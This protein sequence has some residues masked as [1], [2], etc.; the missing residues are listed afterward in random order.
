MHGA[1]YGGRVD[2]VEAV[3]IHLAV[4]PCIGEHFDILDTLTEIEAPSGLHNFADFLCPC[5]IVAVLLRHYNGTAEV[6]L[7]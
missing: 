2:A 7:Q 3:F 5:H 4:F 6:L 1:G